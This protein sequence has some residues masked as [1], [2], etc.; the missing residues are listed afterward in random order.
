VSQRLY[1][2]VIRSQALV[3][4]DMKVFDPRGARIFS[5][6]LPALDSYDIYLNKPVDELNVR[7]YRRDFPISSPPFSTINPKAFNFTPDEVTPLKRISEFHFRLYVGRPGFYQITDNMERKYGATFYFF[8]AY[9]PDPK[10]V[11]SLVQPLRYISTNEEFDQLTSSLEMKKEVDA[12][13]L[14]I[15]DNPDRA[16]ELIRAYYS[17]VRWAN[18]HFSSYLE[19]WKSDRGM[20]YIV[21]GPP[22]A[23]YRSTSTETWRYGEA[24][25]FNALTL[26]FTKVVNPFTFNDFRLN[27]SVSLRNPWYRAVEFW[28]QGRVITYR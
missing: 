1:V 18:A 2:D 8:D 16:R 7:Y 17:R 3:E 23:V 4:Q 28:R 14:R 15:G 24:G 11:L 12:Y 19:G 9:Y 27:R 10:T 20:C 21:F 26:T 13:W 22:D 6:Y 5:P 25:N